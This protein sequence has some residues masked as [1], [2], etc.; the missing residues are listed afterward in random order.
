MVHL[1]HSK[2]DGNTAEV[3]RRK[4]MFDAVPLRLIPTCTSQRRFAAGTLKG[5][6]TDKAKSL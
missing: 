2:T 3:G 1:I 5:K 4:D 6:E